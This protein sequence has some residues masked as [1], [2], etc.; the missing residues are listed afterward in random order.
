MYWPVSHIH[1]N[2]FD[3]ILA[4]LAISDFVKRRERIPDNVLGVCAAKLLSKKRQVGGEVD[5]LARRILDHLLQ[6]VVGLISPQRRVHILQVRLAYEA[7]PVL[8]DHVERLFELLDLR[9]VEHRED[10]RRGS[11]RAFLR[12]LFSFSF[13][14]HVKSEMLVTIVSSRVLVLP[15]WP[16]SQQWSEI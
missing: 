1:Q 12:C 8:I 5:L 2:G 9:L 14:R 7:V 3:H 4:Q 13:G 11:L 10:V 16:L 15:R 6:I